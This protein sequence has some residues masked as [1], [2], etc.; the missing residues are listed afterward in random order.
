MQNI[1]VFHSV[2]L[3][4]SHKAKNTPCQDAALSYEDADNGIYI[5][6]VS[7]GHGNERHFMSDHGSK[8]LVKVSLETIKSFIETSECNQLS[9]PFASSGVITNHDDNSYSDE[10]IS[11]RKPDSQA[12]LLKGLISSIISKWNVAIEKDWSEN[13]PS[14]EYMEKRNVPELSIKDFS[15]GNCIEYAYG[16]TLIAFAKTPAFWIAF[17]IGDG[18]CIA[19]DEN[20]NSYYPIPD[21]ERFSGSKTASMCN[22]DTIDNFRYCYGNTKEPVTVFLGSDGLDGVFGTMDEFSLPQL[23]NFYRNIIKTF[24][25]KGFD[26]TIKEID[27]ALPQLSTKGV[28][29]D[30]M[31]LA[32]VIDM[33]EIPKLLASLMKKNIELVQKELAL[34]VEVHNKNDEDT[35]EKKKEIR[36]KQE[37]VIYLRNTI[38][39]QENIITNS[40]NKLVKVSEDL[41]KREIEV[42]R[43]KE[44]L[45]HLK[46]E[47]EKAIKTQEAVQKKMADLIAEY[48]EINKEQFSK[49]DSDAES[50]DRIS[51]PDND[52]VLQ[53]M[54]TSETKK[55]G[56]I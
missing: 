34:T 39:E 23:E 48:N 16:C 25:K 53:E 46:L 33:I 26:A 47:L 1:R 35:L 10:Q 44:D 56:G 31:S 50:K 8:I 13:S 29:R 12:I 22:E 27:E 51:N 42:Q 2:A 4:E 38:K 19:F 3:G 11:S 6:L 55:N 45:Y 52:D 14:I 40:K 18:T 5:A 32:G 15:N 36:Q 21:D 17:Q 37:E 30:D 7:D 20:A 54:S 43:A 41:K 49:M 24:I 28:T 9:V